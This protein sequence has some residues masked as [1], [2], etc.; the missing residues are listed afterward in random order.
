MVLLPKKRLKKLKILNILATIK[1]ERDQYAN[2][3]APHFVQEVKKKLEQKL[4]V[5]VVGAGGLTIKTTVDLKAQGIAEAAVSAGA[6][7]L[8][9]GGC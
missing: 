9:I 5:K 8:Y 1:P 7:T 3:K 6:Q 2:I 4:G